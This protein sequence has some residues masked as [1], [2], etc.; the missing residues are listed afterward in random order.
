MC[1]QQITL[2]MV[3]PEIEYKTYTSKELNTVQ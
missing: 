1:H 3:T 2:D